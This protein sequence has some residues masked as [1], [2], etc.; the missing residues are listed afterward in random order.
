M[1]TK[2]SK[3]TL[4]SS[5]HDYEVN[6]FHNKLS[7]N[8]IRQLTKIGKAFNHPI[9]TQHIKNQLENMLHFKKNISEHADILT[10]NWMMN[11]YAWKNRDYITE[12]QKR[13]ERYLIWKYKT[14]R[15]QRVNRRYIK[16]R[17]NL[18]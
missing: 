3:I 14:T 13:Y 8:K 1:H 5:R 10:D 16:N 2:Y 18:L 7:Q 11:I 17:A 15:K 12:D 6:K 4:L 9:K